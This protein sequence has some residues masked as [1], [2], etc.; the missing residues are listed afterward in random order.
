VALLSERLARV[1]WPGQDA[2]G[3]KFARGGDELFEIVGVTG[4]VRADPDR[5][6]VAMIY[7]PYWDWAPRRVMLT[8]RAAGD[9]RSIAGAIRSA[10]RSVD[11]EVPVPEMQ[12]MREI[13][14][15][16]I[17]QRKFQTLLSAAFAGIALLLAA[18]GIYGVVSFSVARRTNEMGVR[19]ALGA[20]PRNLRRM[21]VR[22]AMVPVVIGLVAGSLTA[23]LAGRSI[24]GL[25]YEMSAHDP[26]VIVGVAG[27]LAA[28][29]LVASWGPAYRA[30]TVDPLECL[31]YE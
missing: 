5:P 2:V 27:L 24:R 9:P 29:G 26:L 22:Q 11:P 17:A 16:S 6:A 4:D 8:V 28:V 1:L 14:D 12:T 7:R 20:H 25:L 13:L 19:M 23:L 18:L 30:S 10:I 3:R 15:A 21:V 31:R